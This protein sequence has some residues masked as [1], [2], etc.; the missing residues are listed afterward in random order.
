MS[1][2]YYREK[3]LRYRDKIKVLNLNKVSDIICYV[4]AVK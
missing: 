3:I 4:G 2:R 1:L